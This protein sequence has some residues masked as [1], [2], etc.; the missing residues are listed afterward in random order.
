MSGTISRDVRA[1]LLSDSG[2]KLPA[3]THAV[4]HGAKARPLKSR[5]GRLQLCPT[6]VKTGTKLSH[7]PGF[8]A[9][10]SVFL[11]PW[12]DSRHQGSATCCF[13]RPKLRRRTIPTALTL[14]ADFGPVQRRYCHQRS[15]YCPWTAP[16]LL[17]S[18]WLR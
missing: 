2:K 3:V 15:V 6:H 12:R 18:C 13:I 16:L 10:L 9:L 7:R 17:S 5:A 8:S 14:F 4:L 11:K 1:H